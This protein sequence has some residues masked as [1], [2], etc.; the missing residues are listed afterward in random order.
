M[1]G[2]ANEPSQAPGLPEQIVCKQN[3]HHAWEE[4]RGLEQKEWGGE[5]AGGS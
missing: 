4:P 2:A 1:A 5:A 3:P